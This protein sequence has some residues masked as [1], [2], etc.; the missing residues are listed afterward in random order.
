[1]WAGIEWAD[2]AVGFIIALMILGIL[3]AS[4]KPVF[5]RLMD[6][7]E[8]GVIDELTRAAESVGGVEGVDRVRARWSGHRMEGDATI[9]VSD[10]LDVMT[11]HRITD[12][13]EHAMLH[14]V[15]NINGV[16]VHL[17]P[18]HGT[19]E[20]LHELAGHHVSALARQ[21]YRERQGL[22]I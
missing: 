21:R 13:V 14:A 8:E 16:V 6:G 10:A 15:P 9:R 5:R 3:I 19:D 11:A 1:V 22:T 4:M 2:A 7:V 12:E 18:V 17:H 20:D